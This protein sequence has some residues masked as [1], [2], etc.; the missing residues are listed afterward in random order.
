MP[1]ETKSDQTVQRGG[2]SPEESLMFGIAAQDA[3]GASLAGY[4]ARTDPRLQLETMPGKIASLQQQIATLKEQDSYYADLLS[5][6]PFSGDL[7]PSWRAAR[8]N[9]AN[10][11]T[12]LGRQINQLEASKPILTKQISRLGEQEEQN[13]A[14]QQRLMSFIEGKDLGV[15]AE[16]RALIT[17]GISGISQDVATTRGLNRSDVPG[18]QA[19]AP[20][21]SQALLAQANANRSLFTGINQFQQGLNLSNRQTQA[22]LASQNPAANLAGVYSG[23]RGSNLSSGNQQGYGGLDYLTM[24]G[25]LAGGLGLGFYGLSSAGILG[26]AGAGASSSAAAAPTLSAYGGGAAVGCWIAETTS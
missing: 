16:E 1:P 10:Q 19:V 14:V 5:R 26:G 4:E 8:G 11:I 12:E 17:Q 25:T 21:V 24:S 2:A 6:H 22:G 7:Q 20:A 23:L 9:F 18:M 3:A 13:R 15:S